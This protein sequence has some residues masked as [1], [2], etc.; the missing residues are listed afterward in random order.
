MMADAMVFHLPDGN[1]IEV[2]GDGKVLYDY[3]P[4]DGGHRAEED[5]TKTPLGRILRWGL[6]EDQT[7]PPLT[8]KS[9]EASSLKDAPNVSLPY[10][11]N[12]MK[13]N[14]TLRAASNLLEDSVRQTLLA[15]GVPADAVGFLSSQSGYAR[16][17][18]N[19]TNP[20]K[21]AR[22]MMSKPGFTDRCSAWAAKN[23]KD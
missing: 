12:G 23:G 19:S 20:I 13:G 11:G 14:G 1:H 15:G 21:A 7:D 22:T 3:T 18:N 17:L 16:A 4:Y 5:I 2:R 8:G 9:L 10:V 6:L